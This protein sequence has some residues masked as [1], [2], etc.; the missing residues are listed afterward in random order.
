[1]AVLFVLFVL[2]HGSFQVEAVR[3]GCCG[4]V[5]PTRPDVLSALVSTWLKSIN[6][7][8]VRTRSTP[9]PRLCPAFM[10]IRT[11]LKLAAL[12]SVFA[13]MSDAS[14]PKI[15]LIGYL[16]PSC[17]SCPDPSSLLKEIHPAY[18][19][20]VFAFI[21]WDGTGALV[22]QWDAPDKSFTL[23]KSTVAALQA[24]GFKVRRAARPFLC[25]LRDRVSRLALCCCLP[26]RCS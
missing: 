19:H 2:A 10:R 7:C 25:C 26:G 21:G 11:A 1:M 3:L 15:P 9:Y 6:V 14:G 17:P 24:S 5:A 16:C 13:H 18:T 8:A 20:I 23:S 4:S 12:V 22:N